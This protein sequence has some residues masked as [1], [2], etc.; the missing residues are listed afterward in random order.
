MRKD[1][2]VT[3]G[4]RYELFSP[5]LN[6]Q[7]AIANFTAANGGGF[8]DATGGDWFQRGLIR[9]D[10]NDWAPRLGLFIK[11]MGRLVLRGGYGIFYQQDVRIGSESV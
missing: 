6:H 2:T 1:L 7:N 8:V 9:P 10:K 5:L 4:V 11:P 3:Y